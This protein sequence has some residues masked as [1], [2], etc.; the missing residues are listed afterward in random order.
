MFHDVLVSY[1]ALHRRHY[2]GGGAQVNFGRWRRPAGPKK[3]PAA[4]R[5]RR[6]SLISHTSF[7]LVSFSGK[8]FCYQVMHVEQ[9]FGGC[10]A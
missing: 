6:T 1:R 9:F 2:V 4:R 10:L 8:N 3:S 7:I 5:G